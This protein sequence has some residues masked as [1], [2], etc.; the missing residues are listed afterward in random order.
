MNAAIE[1]RAPLQAR[2][3]RKR[4][5]APNPSPGSRVPERS[6]QSRRCKALVVSW[7]MSRI[8]Y[9][10]DSQPGITRKK[11][12]H[13]W[14]YWDAEGKRIT[15]REEIERLN[16]IGLPPAYQNA[17]FNPN[18]NGHIQAVGWDDKGRKQ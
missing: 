1:V 11:V 15:D 4:L 6:G 8:V 5:L 10:D 17:W 7:L 13:G 12:R 14:G 18:P 2:T 9:C 3:P 16:A